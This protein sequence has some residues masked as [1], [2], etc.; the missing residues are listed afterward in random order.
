MGDFFEKIKKQT[1]FI[2]LSERPDRLSHVTQELAKMEIEGERVN[3][4][5]MSNGAIGCSLSHI[6]CL[7]LAKE[8]N[9]PFVFICEDDITFLNP[10]ELKE[11]L[12]KFGSFPQ[13]VDC[14]DVLII[15]GNNLPPYTLIDDFCIKITNCQTTTGYIV[16]KHYYDTLINNFKKSTEL[17]IKNNTKESKKQYA[18]DIYWKKLQIC[19]NWFMVYPPSVT[20]YQNYSNIEEKETNYSHLMLDAKKEWLINAHLHN[21]QKR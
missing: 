7:E 15:G 19:G 3:A 13:L 9:F 18:I 21:S 1:F 14:F 4:I 12:I 10:Q 17:F 20:Q 11:K 6:K 16:N 2:N 5:K 8:K